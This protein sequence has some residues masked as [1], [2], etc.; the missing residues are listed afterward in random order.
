MDLLYIPVYDAT[1]DETYL[2][3]LVGD[4]PPGVTPLTADEAKAS[5]MPIR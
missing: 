2:K 5:G 4:A 3:E 1:T